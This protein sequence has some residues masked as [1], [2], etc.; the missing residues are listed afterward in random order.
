MPV[1][2]LY[3]ASR[4]IS[5]DHARVIAETG[6][7]VGI[8]H[9]FPSLDKYVEGLKEMVDVVGVD[10]V[11]IGTDQQ[12]ARS[13]RNGSNSS[14]LCCE[15]GSRPRRLARSRGET[16]SAFFVLRSANRSSPL[17]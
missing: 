16:I 4:Q 13:T 12:V 17:T 11:C 8:W 9:F 3:A 6:G 10:H 1:R 5:P 15:A 14:R 7:A 2:T